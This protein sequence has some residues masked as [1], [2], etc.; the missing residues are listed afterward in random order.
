MRTGQF[1]QWLADRGH[2]VVFFTGTMDH[3]ARRLRSEDTVIYDVAPNYRI[4]ALAGRLYKRSI[5]LARFRNHA[6]V[7]KS[8]ISA[9]DGMQP[10]DVVLASYPTEELCRA[11]LNY[12]EPRG[13][14]VVIDTRDFWPDIFSEMLPG[15][16]RMLAPLVFSPIERAASK[17]L[18]RATA[19]SGM[20]VSA[21]RWA[22]SKARRSQ[23]EADFWFPF[24]YP[25]QRDVTSVP[26]SGVRLIF[27]G[28]LSH[29]SNIETVID[30]M[31]VLE[32]RGVDATFDICGT[33]QA[34]ASLAARAEG[35][36]SVKFHGWITASELADIMARSDLG[37]LPYVRPDF[38]MSLPNKFVEYLAGGLGVLSC[39][40]G[41]VRQMIGNRDCGIWA[42]SD[43][44]QIADAIAGLQPGRVR[45]I[46]DNAGSVFSDTFGQDAVF[47]K[48]LGCLAHIA[49]KESGVAAENRQ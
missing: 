37:V 44:L 40:E 10:P 42:P 33:G 8:F 3:Y 31:K 21:L 14:P 29:R 13:V 35:L 48:A 2:E 38:H 47:G 15:P 28:T 30:A 19:L 41:E 9:A 23:N 25:S 17:T 36:N 11:I 4:V 18:S 1:A 43:P 20:T 39:T 6:D 26:H 7:A 24:S 32:D 16:L 45:E 27:L 22:Q 46:K 34:E 49:R 12:C 5:S